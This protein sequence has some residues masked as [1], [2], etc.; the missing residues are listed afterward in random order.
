MYRENRPKNKTLGQHVKKLARE[1]QS[2]KEAEKGP[3]K[4]PIGETSRVIKIGFT[5]FW[6][7]CFQAPTINKY[8]LICN[9]IRSQLSHL[10][11]QPLLLLLL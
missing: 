11:Q 9:I 4:S 3:K 8:I 1:K 2:S 6:K 7:K 10:T 5:T